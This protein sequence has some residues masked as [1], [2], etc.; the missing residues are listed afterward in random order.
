M[1]QDPTILAKQLDPRARFP[2]KGKPNASSVDVFAL[3]GGVLAPGIRMTFRT[4]YSFTV[5]SGVSV[6]VLPKAKLSLQHD[7]HMS[8][9]AG[10]LDSS[11]SGELLIRLINLSER[12]YVVEAGDPIAQLLILNASS[13]SPDEGTV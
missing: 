6:L 5:P 9:G 7:V 2:Q 1:T 10:L 3:N 4:G 11:F 13:L 8:L 12:H